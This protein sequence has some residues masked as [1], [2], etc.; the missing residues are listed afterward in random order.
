VTK[1]PV[2]TAMSSGL[3]FAVGLGVAG[4]TRPSKIIGFLDVFSGHWDPSL[5]FVMIGAIGVHL[6]FYRWIR[7][8]AGAVPRVGSCGPIDPGP[9]SSPSTRIDGRLL[10]G[11]AIFGVG[12]G[13]G[14]YCPGPAV[15]SV[16]SG[17]P[18]VL[19]FFAAMLVGMSLAPSAG[20]RSESSPKDLH[21]NVGL[22]GLRQSEPN[23][24]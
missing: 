3:I 4:M 12:W 7:A 24:T 15:V 6:P 17:A 22:S 2:L 18:G 1:R 5:A 19:I 10:L 8:R 14:G 9:G 16:A 21:P 11:A 20:A 23:E 13:L